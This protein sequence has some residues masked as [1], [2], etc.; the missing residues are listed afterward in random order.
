MSRVLVVGGTGLAGCAVTS[1]AVERGHEVVVASR[2]VP[3]DD[4]EQ[5]VPGAVYETAD[6]VTGDG[7]ENALDGV[8]VLIDVTNGTG[9]AAAHVFAHGSQNLLHTAARFGV[10]QAVL[11]SIV[12]VDR[13]A[14]AYYR[15][16]AAQERV[17]RES[18]LNVRILRATQFHD[19]VSAIFARGTLGVIPVP[20]KT[21]FQPIA[22]SDVARLLLDA[23]EGQ[24]EADSTLTVGGP[25][26]ETARAL[27]E[28]WKAATGAR[29]SIVPV[30][31]RGALGATWRAGDNLV[32]EAAVPG[33][34]YATWLGSLSS[35]AV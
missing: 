22:V 28:Q 19:L 34:D 6:V 18:P 12:N 35:N 9:R 4:S 11:L 21:S 30:R 2:G 33:I 10:H 3:D 14:Y 29:G 7:L 1:E 27:A 15:A 5:Y 16:K 17:Y 20:A 31:L 13:S 32:P 8:D 24:G 25:K 23:A 26:V